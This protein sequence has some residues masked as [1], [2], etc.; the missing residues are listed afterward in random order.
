M[1]V[2]GDRSGINIIG[3]TRREVWS[4]KRAI[5]RELNSATEY[6]RNKKVGNLKNLEMHIEILEKLLSELNKDRNGE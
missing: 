2:S 3:L 1:N 4:L 5:E 6:N